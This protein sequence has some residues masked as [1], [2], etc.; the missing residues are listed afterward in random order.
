MSDFRKMTLN[1][2]RSHP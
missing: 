1:S 2:R